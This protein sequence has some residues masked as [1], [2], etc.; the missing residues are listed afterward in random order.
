MVRAWA[1]LTTQTQH[2][3]PDMRIPTGLSLLVIVIL[4]PACAREAGSCGD[5]E[6][7]DG[8]G[9]SD[10]A[11]TECLLDPICLPCGDGVLD[12][13]ESCD[14][15]NRDDGDGCSSSCRIDECG[16]DRLD[17]GE[18][19]DDGNLRAGDGCNDR[20]QV[21]F[22]GDGVQQ[23]R[24]ECDD[25]N[26]L[27]RDGCSPR[28]R[29]ELGVL[30]GNAVFDLGEQCDDGNRRA[31]DGC[32]PSCQAEF[33][34]DGIAQSALGEQCDGPD[35]P[36]GEVCDG[37]R[38]RTCGNGD[39]DVGE[40]CDDGNDVFDDGCHFCRSERCGDGILH[41]NLS[42]ECDDGGF[43]PG[44]GCSTQCLIEFCGDGVVQR[45]MDEVCEGV[46]AVVV[47]CEGCQPL[48]VDLD[49][50]EGGPSLAFEMLE[51]TAAVGVVAAAIGNF[52]SG[53]ELLFSVPTA[54]GLY[55]LDRSGPPRLFNGYP[56]NADLVIADV[57]GTPVPEIIG[58]YS[59]LYVLRSDGQ[60]IITYD[61]GSISSG[62]DIAHFGEDTAPD[63]V[64]ASQAGLLVVD[65]VTTAGSTV[66]PTQLDE[67]IIDVVVRRVPSGDEIVVAHP[68]VLRTFRG[69]PAGPMG[70]I[71]EQTD[72]LAWPLTPRELVALDV[73]GDGVEEL[74]VLD[75]QGLTL[76]KDGEGD[77]FLGV[78]VAT[79]LVA[80]PLDDDALPDLVTI[81][82]AQATVWLSSQGWQPSLPFP[83]PLSAI[84]V[85]GD[86][87]DDQ[88][89]ELILMGG[90]R[91]S[92]V[93]VVRFRP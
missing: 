69:D 19:C 57:T 7:N 11:D 30:C 55:R 33:C 76:R 54:G 18:E 17:T 93:H 56:S 50:I 14:D 44:D 81:E 37:C 87:D 90:S 77:R 88:E 58:A 2:R 35:T 85:I 60:P 12:D 3:K 38:I 36:A 28:C 53:N 39:L 74:V 82:A 51:G 68:R 48:F 15:G 59:F 79:H 61:L 92:A 63:I 65:F 86:L 20:C 49:G 52:G 43:L 10:C 24:E 21:D 32:G 67:P 27:P 73:D 66:L 9:V 23:P 26:L 62:V 47:S 22:C 25:G 84:G 64:V 70:P 40:E 8:D 6:D 13:A 31:N 83:T 89:P 75:D 1:S 80:G 46:D 5:G 4:A 45:P 91:S 78:A 71:V 16:N 41:T 29:I 34:G 72:E 42:E